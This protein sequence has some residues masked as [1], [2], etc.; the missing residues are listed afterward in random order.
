[1]FRQRLRS[2]IPRARVGGGAGG[3]V[4]QCAGVG[5]GAGLDE[6]VAGELPQERGHLSGLS[7][8]MVPPSPGLVSSR[9]SGRLFG[10]RQAAL[11]VPGEGGDPV[12]RVAVLA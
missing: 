12:E 1:M 10:V 11:G 5:G 8:V 2:A 3:G 4:A 6:P 7:S 9:T